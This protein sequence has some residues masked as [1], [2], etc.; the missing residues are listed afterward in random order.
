VGGYSGNAK[1]SLGLIAL[2]AYRRARAQRA[3]REGRAETVTAIPEPKR[4]K[5]GWF[6]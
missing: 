5:R 2:I 6:G 1:V 3:L 4:K